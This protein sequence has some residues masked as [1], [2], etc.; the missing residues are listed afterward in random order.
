[1]NRATRYRRRSAAWATRAVTER[2]VS[3]SRSPAERSGPCAGAGLRQERAPGTNRA[4][5]AVGIARISLG[6]VGRQGGF[7]IRPRACAQR[8]LHGAGQRDRRRRQRGQ[9]QW[10]G[11]GQSHPRLSQSDAPL[12]LAQRRRRPRYQPARLQA[13]QGGRGQVV[14]KNASGSCAP[15]R[16]GLCG[17]APPASPGTAWPTPSRLGGGHTFTV[18]AVNSSAPSACQ[19]RL[20]RPYPSAERAIRLL[21]RLR[22]QDRL[23][24]TP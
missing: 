1:V 6:D 23:Q 24:S 13:C 5:R 12:L 9:R 4:R 7:V 17:R 19:V 15:S 8:N 18:A 16:W 20:H 2:T 14:V 22:R 3:H 10:I 21:D 11:Q